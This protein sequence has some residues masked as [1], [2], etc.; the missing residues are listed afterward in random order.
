MANDAAAQAAIPI[1]SAVQGQAGETEYSVT[2]QLRV[3]D[4]TDLVAVDPPHDDKL[5]PHYHCLVFA[6]TGIGYCSTPPNQILLGIALF[7]TIFIMAPV[8]TQV[9]DDCAL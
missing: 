2:L 8:F 9:Y 4:G 3:D 6:Q 7:L 5:Y 1:L